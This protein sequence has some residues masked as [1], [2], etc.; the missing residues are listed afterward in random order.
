ML[1]L[2][3]LATHVYPLT[4]VYYPPLP[5]CN[6]LFDKHERFISEFSTD[7]YLMHTKTIHVVL[8]VICVTLGA[9]EN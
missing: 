9:L 5:T 1:F 6:S 7:S 3:I 2:V 8:M 4:R